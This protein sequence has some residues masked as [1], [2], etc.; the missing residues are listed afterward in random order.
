LILCFDENPGVV[1]RLRKNRA[2]VTGAIEETL[3]YYSPV[4]AMPRVTTSET[5]L[6]DQHIK[7]G[8]VIVAWIGSANRDEAAFPDPDRFDIEREPN[9]HIAFG[10]GIHFCLGAPLARLEAKVALNAML[11]RL[12]GDW[13]VADQPLEMVKSFVVF[14]AKKLPMTWGG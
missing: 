2:L 8:Q 14:G 11:D 7:A 9:R 6:G 12:P 4:K 1:E 3:R 5:T 13:Q 10:H